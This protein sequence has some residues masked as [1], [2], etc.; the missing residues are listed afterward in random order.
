M[1]NNNL[2]H[3]I[4]HG[5]LKHCSTSTALQQITDI[6]LQATDEGKLNAALFLYLSAIFDV[7]DLDLLLHKLKLYNFSDETE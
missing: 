5:F 6:W 1:R 7:I 4:H 3:E 2:I